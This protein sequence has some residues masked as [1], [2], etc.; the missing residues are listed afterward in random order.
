MGGESPSPRWSAIWRRRRRAALIGAAVPLIAAI[1]AVNLIEPSYLAT[2]GVRIEG[3]SVAA[4]LT[5]SAAREE[6]VQHVAALHQKVLEAIG[7]DQI[8]RP[9]QESA[10]RLAKKLEL[11]GVIDSFDLSEN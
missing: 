11:K 2:A 1:G 7:V 10:E 4:G 8:V 5:E 9:E 3:R 6:A